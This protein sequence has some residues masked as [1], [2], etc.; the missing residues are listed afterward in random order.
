MAK[1]DLVVFTGTS[2]P[3][4]AKEAVDWMDV[5]LG[6]M[7]IVRFSDGEV[8]VE[9]GESLRGKDVFIIQ[10]TS[11]PVNEMLMEMLIMTDAVRRSEASRIHLI[12]PYFGYSRKERK[13]KPRDPITGRLVADFIKTA[14]ADQVV[15]FD[16]H[17]TA[18]EG[19]FSIPSTHVL[20]T[21][22]LANSFLEYKR[23][24]GKI[25]N[26]LR[27]IPFKT[28]DDATRFKHVDDIVIVAPD[29]GGAKRA[30]DFGRYL[31]SASFA[32]IE[33]RRPAADQT[34][35]LNII[36]DVEGKEAIIVDDM[37]ATGG[38]MI[39]LVQILRDKG[40][41]KVYGCVT[42]PVFAKNAVENLKKANFDALFV[43]NSIWLPE[44]KRWDNLF[45]VSI[46]DLLGAVITRIHENRSV[47]EIFST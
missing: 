21:Q 6:A 5:S 32:I 47:S 35:I 14:G 31:G 29:M 41:T 26:Y 43:T 3:H 38:T 36:G 8:D 20:A 25:P 27:E 15:C 40:A 22:L 44:D 45:I 12:I 10:S 1:N 2:N 9:I 39:P 34:E 17:A 24:E 19:F 28:L 4:L 30:R 16:L 23:R 13:T 18:L 37:I 42:H 7:K 11:T 33:K 46:G